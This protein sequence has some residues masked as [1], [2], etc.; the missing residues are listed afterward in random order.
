M[1]SYL[2]RSELEADTFALPET[3]AGVTKAADLA[4]QIKRESGLNTTALVG[5]RNAR[6]GVEAGIFLAWSTFAKVTFFP[7]DVLRCYKLDASP[8]RWHP[9]VDSIAEYRVLVIILYPKDYISLKDANLIV[10]QEVKNFLRDISLPV[11]FMGDFNLIPQTMA[12]TDL[13]TD[14]KMVI[15]TPDLDATCSTLTSSGTDNVLDYVILDP[16]LERAIRTQG[17]LNE[18]KLH[19]GMLIEFLKQGWSYS[20]PALC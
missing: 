6:G 5:N 3:H 16:I 15:I 1:I 13:V 19:A 17:V 8:T 11:M 20:I 18:I 7:E 10:L 14:R 9:F 12:T 4:K 2:A